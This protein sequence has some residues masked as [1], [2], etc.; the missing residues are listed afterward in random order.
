M[1]KISL[2]L[3]ATLLGLTAC[4]SVVIDTPVLENEPNNSG[5]S[6]ME[7]VD[8]DSSINP[9]T[10][11]NVDE[12][13]TVHSS[14][15]SSID[16]IDTEENSG[17]TEA[18]NNTAD[19]GGED[20]CFSHNLLYHTFPPNFIDYVGRENYLEWINNCE[21]ICSVNI[22]AF[23]EHFQIPKEVTENIV[24]EISSGV[25]EEYYEFTG[26]APE[27]VFG[28]TILNSVQI[29]AI[30]SGNEA[31]IENA[32]CGQ[33]HVEAEDGTRYS[34][35]WLNSHSA[36]DYAE[37]GISIEAVTELA[38]TI[39]ADSMYSKYQTEAASLAASAAELAVIESETVTE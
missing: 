23:I 6:V 28:V 11:E 26:L 30:Y 27:D 10:I 24:A 38:A 15:T 3:V 32:F 1:K 14:E 21:G 16:L 4:N 17:I 25:N 29:D 34:L 5:T 22:A 2:I 9:T 35:T 19:L 33:L 31:Q 37:A 20:W 7:N 12:D 13:K 39:N 18:E 8:I 36:K